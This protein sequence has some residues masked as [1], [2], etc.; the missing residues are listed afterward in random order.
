ML[1]DEQY[2][3]ML[4]QNPDLDRHP[5]FLLPGDETRDFVGVDTESTIV[6]DAESEMQKLKN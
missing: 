3:R 4:N 1:D 2:E 5:D 6:I